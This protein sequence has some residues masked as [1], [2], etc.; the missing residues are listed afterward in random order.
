M[1]IP[2][3]LFLGFIAM[4]FILIVV[5]IVRKVPALMVISGMFILFLSVVSTGI[6]MGKIP[7]SS[8]TSGATTTYT[9]QDN[10]FVFTNTT[11]VIFALFGGIVMIIG[12]LMMRDD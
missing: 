3:E 7:V 1:N 9:F 4:T 12:A 8:V 5:G 11:K 6:I 10:V 2:I